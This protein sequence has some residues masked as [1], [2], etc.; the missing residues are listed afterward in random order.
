MEGHVNFVFDLD[1]TLVNEDTQK[2][3]KIY[4]DNVSKRFHKRFKIDAEFFTNCM[5]KT[6]K[7]MEEENGSQTIEKAFNHHLSHLT[8]ISTK[9]IETEFEVFYN[10][11][12]DEILS[13]LKEI[14]QMNAAT[15]I[16]KEKGCRLFVATDPF[17]PKLAVDKKIAH[18][19]LNVNDFDFV[20]Y[21]NNLNL[22]KANNNFFAN[23]FEKLNLDPAN[24]IVVGNT[25]PTDI[26]NFAVKQTYII[27][28]FLKEKGA[29]N[30]AYTLIDCNQFLDIAKNI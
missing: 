18:C 12:Y 26:P 13:A 10:N 25:I 15:K 14:P 19:N 2:L 24:T 21:N 28:D 22:V 7:K 11:E 20:S 23:L 9:D 16:L 5:Y 1:G 29:T 8:G 6:M 17:L 27:K 3:Y 4:F 30:N